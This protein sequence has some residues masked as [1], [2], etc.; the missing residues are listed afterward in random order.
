MALFNFNLEAADAHS[1]KII[2]PYVA[3]IWDE[4]QCESLCLFQP[5]KHY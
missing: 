3:G 2:D 1:D 4:D 5:S